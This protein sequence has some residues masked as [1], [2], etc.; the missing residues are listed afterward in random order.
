MRLPFS[1]TRRQVLGTVL[2]MTGMF[3]AAMDVSVIGTAMPTVIG[4]LGGIDRYGWVFSAYLL[5]STTM[6]PVFGRLADMFGRKPLYFLALV[7]FVIASMLCGTSRS[8]D[9]LIIYRAL[10]GVGAGALIPTGLTMIGDLFDRRTRAKIVGVFSS[11]WVFSAI[12]GPIIGAFITETLSWRWTFYVNLPIGIAALLLLIFTFRESGEHHRQRIDFLGS[13]LF[14]LAAALLMLG[15]NGLAPLA[16]L[17][18]AAVL[19]VAFVR[20]EMRT[21]APMIDLALVRQP[22]IAGILALTLASGVMQFG[23][24]SYLPPY[25]QG[26]QDGAPADAGFALAGLSIGWSFGSSAVGW[27]LFRVGLRTAVLLG[28]VMMLLG[29]L[30]LTLLTPDT[31]LLMVVAASTA[32]GLGMGWAS[33]PAFVTAQ[34]SVGYAQRGTV[35]SLLTFSRTLGG[36]VGVAALGSLLNARLGPLARDASALLDPLPGADVAAALPMRAA[37][38]DGLHWIYL[39]LL[40]VSVAAIALALRMPAE[41]PEEAERFEIAA[42]S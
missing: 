6:T 17:P 18:A 26:V 13:A 22:L 41:M 15:L 32:V 27:I 1:A 29:F 39:A 9:E 3:V 10:Q 4:E 30:W 20:V 16:T 33:M 35:T 34:T 40:G 19:G 28:S 38:A 25:V 12:I 23:V 37:L 36:A 5:T 31:A 24:M 2:V 14:T 42:A 21:E 8:M 7:T 11:V